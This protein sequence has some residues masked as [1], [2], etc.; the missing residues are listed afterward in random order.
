VLSASVLLLWVPSGNWETKVGE[1]YS[2]VYMRVGDWGL[3]HALKFPYAA[4]GA[5]VPEMPTIANLSAT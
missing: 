3:L 2:E 4:C 5:C 1:S